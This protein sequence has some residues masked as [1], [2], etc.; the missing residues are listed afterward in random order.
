M[1]SCETRFWEALLL[2]FKRSGGC[3]ELW[4]IKHIT[5]NTI[6]IVILQPHNEI[7]NYCQSWNKVFLLQS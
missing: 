2:A 1:A 3:I 4:T 5:E 7:T 6:Y